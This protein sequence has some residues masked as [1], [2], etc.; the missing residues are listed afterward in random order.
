[1]FRVSRLPLNKRCSHSYLQRLSQSHIEH[2]EL[3]LSSSSILIFLFLFKY[4]SSKTALVKKENK[5]EVKF[6]SNICWSSNG[7]SWNNRIGIGIH[8]EDKNIAHSCCRR[9]Y[10]M[11]CFSA[12][13]FEI[14][15]RFVTLRYGLN[16]IFSYYC[17]EII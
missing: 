16:H 4:V 1:M 9:G 11:L 17:S 12:N 3:T 13:D 6:I 10:K 7:S 14:T 8:E 5:I 15:R 2:F